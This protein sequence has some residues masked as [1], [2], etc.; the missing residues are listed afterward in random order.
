LSLRLRFW[1]SEVVAY[2]ASGLGVPLFREGYLLHLPQATLEV[3]DACSGF[4]SILSLFAIGV[5][6]IYLLKIGFGFK[7]LLSLLLVP[8]GSMTNIVRIATLVLLVHYSG[9][10]A[11]D[12]T[13]HKFSGTF[14]FILGFS[15]ILAVGRVTERFHSRSTDFV[16]A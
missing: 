7:V 5:F 13:F 14:N 1:D 2:I 3:A 12:S 8:I 15:A 16:R 4:F 10:W 11:L 6:Y 9:L